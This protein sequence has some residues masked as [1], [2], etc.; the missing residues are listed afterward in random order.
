MIEMFQ[1]ARMVFW[2]RNCR[3]ARVLGTGRGRLSLY[4]LVEGLR[5]E[6]GIWR[7]FSEN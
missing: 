3:E 5:G 2:G 6:R 4:I 7:D 1:Q